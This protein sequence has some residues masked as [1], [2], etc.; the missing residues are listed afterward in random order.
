VP[1]Q[2][3]ILA[4]RH[5]AVKTSQ[6]TAFLGP[7]I[8]CVRFLGGG[9]NVCYLNFI[10]ISISHKL[11]FAIISLV[12]SMS[13]QSGWVSTPW[14]HVRADVISLEMKFCSLNCFDV[15]DQHVS[16]ERGT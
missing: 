1:L 3:A 8:H 7:K 9:G 11:P 2:V 16:F 14:L 12:Q 15:K 13:S 4:V 10:I 6:K 5:D